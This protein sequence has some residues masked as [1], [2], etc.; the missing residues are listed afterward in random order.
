MAS[1]RQKQTEAII[2]RHFGTVLLQEGRYIFGD[3]FVTVTNVQV[4]PDIS[5]SKIYLSVYNTNDKLSVIE[6]VNEN[7]HLLKKNLA[8]RIKKHVRRIPD[9]SFY[10]DE[11]LDE[12][13]KVDR[14][15]TDL[16]E[17]GGMGEEE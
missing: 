10:L 6:K 2:K 16:R 13:Y 1:I 8:H 14:M 5:M 11:T 9:I 7:V 4:S 15:L 3:A 17:R 12:M